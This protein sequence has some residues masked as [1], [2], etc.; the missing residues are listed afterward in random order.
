M[1]KMILLSS[2]LSVL[3]RSSLHLTGVVAISLASCHDIC[4]LNQNHV[5]ME[6]KEYCFIKVHHRCHMWREKIALSFPFSTCHVCTSEGLD[7]GIHC[8]VL[9]NVFDR[10]ILAEPKTD[11]KDSNKYLGFFLECDLP[12]DME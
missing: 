8:Y 6:S 12:S 10:K 4:L 9:Q 1:N 2:C 11:E 5:L 3:G 7:H